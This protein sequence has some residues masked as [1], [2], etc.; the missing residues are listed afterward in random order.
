[1][2][3]IK[4]KR[5]RVAQNEA[6]LSYQSV[7]LFVGRITTLVVFGIV[8][9]LG[10]PV[11]GADAS[12]YRRAAEPVINPA[13]VPLPPGAIGPNGWLRDRA[14]AARD[15]ITGHL[16]EWHPTFGQAWKGVPISGA[17]GVEPDGAGWPLEQCSYWLDGLIRLG[18]MLHDQALIHKAAAR[19]SL[20]V[21]GVNHG[22]ESFIYWRKNKPEGFNS[23][24]HSQMGRALVAWYEND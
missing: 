18:S 9:V 11:A 20:A 2:T 13:F 22:G 7:R 23:W 12:N 14:L 10:E 19:L 15:G 6:T 8:L 4:A 5:L 17:P 1:L 21:E 3:S 16:D 24:A